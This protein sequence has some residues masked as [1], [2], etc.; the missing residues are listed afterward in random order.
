M[1]RIPYADQSNPSIAP[2]VA[3]ITKERGQVINLYGMLLHSEPV[4]R[5]WLGFLT[6]V[7]QECA[8]RAD[9][10]EAVILRIAVIN[11]A[12]YEFAQHV[13]YAIEAGMTQEQIDTIGAGGVEIGSPPIDA[14][15]A[16]ASEST[17][18]IRVSVECFAKVRAVF[19]ASEIVELTATIG[20]YN[21][22]SRFL[23]ALEIDHD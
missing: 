1:A 18:E 6:A 3:Q 20:A 14:A 22:V 2:L 9:V 23:E 13:P 7:R 21:M 15:L 5:G 16:Y 17:T 12:P 4:A 11:Q 19:D 8:L 10:R